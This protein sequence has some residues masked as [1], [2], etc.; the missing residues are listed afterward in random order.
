MSRS[1][2]LRLVSLVILSCYLVPYALI[3]QIGAWYGSFLFW[4]LAGVAVIVLNI[5]ATAGFTEDAE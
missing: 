5:I 2:S 4:C 3:G 1:L